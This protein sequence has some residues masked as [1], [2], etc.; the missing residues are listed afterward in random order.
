MTIHALVSLIPA[1]SRIGNQ[2][3]AVDYLFSDARIEISGGRQGF[4][5]FPHLSEHHR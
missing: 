4:R 1:M 5:A 3:D 2:H